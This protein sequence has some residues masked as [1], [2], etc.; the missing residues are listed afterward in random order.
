[1]NSTVEIGSIEA[2]Y[3]VGAVENIILG[4][5]FVMKTGTACEI[6]LSASLVGP[7]VQSLNITNFK[8]T[9]NKA[10]IKSMKKKIQAIE[11]TT[12]I[13]QATINSLENRATAFTDQIN[14]QQTS[15]RAIDTR[16][17]TAM[18]R[19]TATVVNTVATATT[20]AA[21][22]LASIG[23]QTQVIGTKVTSNA[24]STNIGGATSRVNSVTNRG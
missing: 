6:A 5:Q 21:S 2:K 11:T 12:N 22:R 10:A 14:A 15:V 19:N 20:A 24:S 18:T 7:A 13:N 9:G 3:F 17:A 16:A 1:M 23:T 8:V 4:V